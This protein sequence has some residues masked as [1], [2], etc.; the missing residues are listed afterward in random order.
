MKDAAEI[1]V[2]EGKSLPQAI[3]DLG[4]SLSSI[5][6][7]KVQ[8]RPTFQRLLWD[9]RNR[10]NREIAD[11]PTRSKQS[12]I[13]QL[14]IIAQKLVE[15]GNY[16]KAAEVLFKLAKLEGWVGNE[17]TVNVFGS[18][19]NADLEKLKAKVKSVE[20]ENKPEDVNPN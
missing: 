4:I 2:R 17:N 7:K 1:M 12:T 10:W 16:D 11:V 19:S 15:E 20:K 5:E 13:G 3:T 8:L 14:Q 6:T 9:A 18:L